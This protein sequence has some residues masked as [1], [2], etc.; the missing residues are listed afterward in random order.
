MKKSYEVL[1]TILLI[2]IIGIC[3]L[4]ISGV[5]AALHERLS[6]EKDV[7][8][9]LRTTMSYYVTKFRH[10][11]AAGKIRIADDQLYL[12]DTQIETCIFVEDGMLY[13]STVLEGTSHS[14]DSA[15]VISEIDDV[16]LSIDSDRLVT[17]TIRRSG[18]TM[19]TKFGLNAALGGVR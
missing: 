17:I 8:D 6:E 4:Q 5:S 11:D 14:K 9:D 16:Q 15:F 2:L 1:C 19:T 10:F 18:R 7:L 13:E 12:Y 3:L